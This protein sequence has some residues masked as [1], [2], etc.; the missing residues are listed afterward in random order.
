MLVLR[1][2]LR[3]WCFATLHQVRS[4]WGGWNGQWNPTDIVKHNNRSGVQPRTHNE[5]R[6]MTPQVDMGRLQ[7]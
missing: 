7:I 1:V 4:Q 3:V 2:L 6:F 5:P